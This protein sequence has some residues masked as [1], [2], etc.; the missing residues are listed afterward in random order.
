MV[1]NPDG[2]WDEG[3]VHFEDPHGQRPGR[4]NGGASIRA[5]CSGA[6]VSAVGS[7]MVMGVVVRPSLGS[8]CGCRGRKIG[9]G[10]GSRF[11]RQWLR[12]TSH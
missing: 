2:G 9:A 7:D 11:N 1:T 4:S 8:S 5:F 3:V 6:K 12:P 10:V